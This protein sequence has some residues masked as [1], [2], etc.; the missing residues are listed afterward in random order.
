MRK[1][2]NDDDEIRGR[3]RLGTYVPFWSLLRNSTL[4]HWLFDESHRVHRL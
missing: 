4:S 1:A 3:L 2:E